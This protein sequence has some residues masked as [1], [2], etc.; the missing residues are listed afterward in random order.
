MLQTDTRG[1]ETRKFFLGEAILK[2]KEVEVVGEEEHFQ[3]TLHP[4]METN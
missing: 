2:S 1:K 3:D 4:R